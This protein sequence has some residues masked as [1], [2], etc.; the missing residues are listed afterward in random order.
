MALNIFEGGRRIAKLTAVLWI[1]IG[2]WQT[3]EDWRRADYLPIE[4]QFLRLAIGLLVVGVGLAFLW[5]LTWA[6]GW[7]VRGFLGIPQGQDQKP[8]ETRE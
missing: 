7:I 5:A 4:D 2:G 8:M 3:I 1:F 6:L